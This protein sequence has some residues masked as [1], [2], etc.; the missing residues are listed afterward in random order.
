MIQGVER[1]LQIVYDRMHEH[2]LQRDILHADETT[3]Q[4]LHEPGRASQ[5][6]SY[7]WLYRSGPE[8]AGHWSRRR[9]VRENGLSIFLGARI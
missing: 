9:A 3:L 2:L 5:T 6:S 7:L 8:R 4:V 1:H